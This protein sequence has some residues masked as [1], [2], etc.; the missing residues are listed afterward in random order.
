MKIASYQMDIVPGN[1][2]E[3][4]KKIT[5]WAEQVCKE[6]KPDILVLPEMW[7]TAYTLPTLEKIIR[8]DEEDTESFLKQL[9]HKLN[10][11]MVAGSIAVWEDGVIYNRSLVLNR[12]GDMIH[13]YDKMHLVPMLDEHLYLKGGNHSAKVFELDGRKMGVIICYDLRFP[14][15]A[16]SLALQ[17]VEV[18]FVV[19]EWPSARA[20]HWEVLQQAR[21]IENQLFVVSCNRIGTYDGVE[22]AG[23]SMVI[24]PW[25]DI[26]SKASSKEEET[27]HATLSLDDVK[28]IRKDVPVF[29][30]RVPNLY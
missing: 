3:N 2:S 11:N 16:R 25:G 23:R 20:G 13:T 28:R 7:T 1:P 5:M 27:V 9:A 8:E 30:S 18:L 4:R 15:L 10:V 22:F 24:N 26:L 14:E 17:G 12:K 6:Q 19:A 29:S 21:A